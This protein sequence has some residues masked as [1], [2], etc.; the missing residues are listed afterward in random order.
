MQVFSWSMATFS[1]AIFISGV[2]I[3]F[4]GLGKLTF[5]DLVFLRN[6]LLSELFILKKF[7]VFRVSNRFL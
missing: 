5:P 2:N 6:L 3:S 7:Y 4:W 1:P